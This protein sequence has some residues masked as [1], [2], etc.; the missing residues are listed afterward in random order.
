MRRMERSNFSLHLFCLF[1]LNFEEHFIELSKVFC[2][3]FVKE[4]LSIIQFFNVTKLL[5]DDWFLFLM[6]LNQFSKKSHAKRGKFTDIQTH[7]SEKGTNPTKMKLGT[8]IP[9]LRKIQNIYK[10]CDTPLEFCQHHYVLPEISKFCYIKK[11][12]YRLHFDT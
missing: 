10:S 3:V 11:D 7:F 1:W 2:S 5:L 12:R 8:V 4:T 6:C 9:Y